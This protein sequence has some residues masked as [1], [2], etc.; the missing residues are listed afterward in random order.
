M[1]TPTMKD[2][3]DKQMPPDS[4][5]I[6]LRAA[7]LV[8]AN[9]EAAVI[10]ASLASVM[11]ALESGDAVHVIADNCQDD[12]AALAAQVGAEVFERKTGDASGKGAA[13]RWYI[14]QAGEALDAFDL[15]VVLDADNRV[16]PGFIRSVKAG[17][18]DGAVYQCLVHPVDYQHSHLGTLIALSEKHEQETID[19]MRTLFGMPVR[20][21]GTGMVFPPALLR[22]L[23]A[24]VD[25]GVE[26]LA[27]TLLVGCEDIPI[28]RINQAVVFDPKPSGSVPASRQ[29]ARWFRGQWVAFW[30][31]RRQVGTLLIKGFKGW[32]LLDALFLK[33]RWLV[34]L[35]CLLIGLL[36]INRIWWLAVLLLLRMLFDFLSLLWTILQSSERWDYLKAILYLPVFISMWL[37]GF[38]LALQKNTWLRARE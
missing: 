34:D 33:P 12:T 6:S 4:D 25:T 19:S 36:L 15:L 7:V 9:N 8:F 32:A 2:P 10:T 3:P 13:I 21:R 22:R 30:R 27:L 14:Q 16:P 24:G 37:R 20:L 23:A 26:D 31:Y 11:A 17:F 18:R 28:R 1:N 5:G 29:R 35:L 38:A